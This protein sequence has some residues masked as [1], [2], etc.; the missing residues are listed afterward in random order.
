MPS[1][2]A[3]RGGGPS[4]QGDA[5]VEPTLAAILRRFI[6][7]RLAHGR[8]VC[9][10]LSG[11]LD[12]VVLLHALSRLRAAGVGCE[13]SAQHVQHG[14]SPHADAWVDSCQ[15]LCQRLDV[16]LA[17]ARVQVPL[18]SGEGIEGA[19][20]RQRQA[21]FARCEAD[22]L[23]LAQHRDDQ[24]ETVLFRLLR[25]A[26]VRGAAGM[27]EER[28]QAAG[29]RLIRPLLGLSRATIA[30]YAAEQALSWVEDESN[31]DL[32]LRRNHLRHEVL[33]CIAQQFPA[34]AQ[35]LARAA[36][37]FAEAA[38]LLDDLAA[39]DR[40]R[41]AGAHGRIDL[42][43]FSL[44]SAARARNLLRH[45]LL[46]AG[47]RAPETRWLDEAL[48]QLAN[49]DAASATCVGTVDGELHV[50][51]DEIHVV[52]QRPAVPT[53]PL[54]WHGEAQLAWG[55]D[56]LSFA[57]ATGDGISRRLL[58]G[59]AVCLR[60]R[61]GG[62]ALQPDPRRPRRSLRKLFQEAGVPPWERNRLPLLCCGE[63]VAWV[64]GFGV[65]AAFACAPGEAGIVVA[66]H[67]GAQQRI[68]QGL[69]SP[70]G[71]ARG[72]SSGR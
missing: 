16:P 45:E 17:I 33:P 59:D 61:G 42:R 71:A 70:P 68:E 9:V 14:L 5:T 50:Y 20:R 3:T 23:A 18:G 66:L 56:R 29:P 60:T 27:P 24:A 65:D 32:R 55:A 4:G 31:A 35:A 52:R 58:A 37:H 36:G 44:L 54:A 38:R 49:A 21:V 25:G 7:P 39:I 63:R 8:R 40:S 69:G 28:S 13:L 47:M 12:S 11:G 51:R 46:V 53:V 22:W 41:V 67:S 34:A 15:E 10:A 2:R 62:E 43:R 19:A 6:A 64:A 26:G 48:R 72:G 57:L 1:S 30:A